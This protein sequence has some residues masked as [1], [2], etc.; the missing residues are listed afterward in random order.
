MAASPLCLQRAAFTCYGRETHLK[1]GRSTSSQLMASPQETCRRLLYH[2][3][4]QFGDRLIDTRQTT[5]AARS[6][7][8]TNS[9]SS[10]FHPMLLSAKQHRG[11]HCLMPRQQAAG[12]PKSE[13]IYYDLNIKSCLIMKDPPCTFRITNAQTSYALQVRY[14]FPCLDLILCH[15]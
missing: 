1:S 7:L 3:S 5:L 10:H 2:K 14:F 15:R 13:R 9:S 4:I 11:E 12:S 8:Q 6:C